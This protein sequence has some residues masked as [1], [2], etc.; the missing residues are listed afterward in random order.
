MKNGTGWFW[1]IA[2]LL[3]G[4]NESLAADSMAEWIKAFN[5]NYPVESAK[6]KKAVN[7]GDEVKEADFSNEFKELLYNLY[8]GYAS[9]ITDSKTVDASVTRNTPHFEFFKK[10]LGKLEYRE[11]EVDS[12]SDRIRTH[13]T[14]LEEKKYRFRWRFFVHY[15]SWQSQAAL[16]GPFETTSLLTTNLGF[17]P[18]IGTSLENRFW[19][20]S[21]DLSGLYGSGGVSAVQGLVEY[22]QSQVPA[23]GG[24]FA[25]GGGRIVSASGSEVGLRGSLLFVR[26]NLTKPSDSQYTVTQDKTLSY[27]ISV[28]SRWRF[29]KFY[30]ETD[31]G[32]T[33]ARPSTLWSIGL[34]SIF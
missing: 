5:K 10:A 9:K 23:L 17:C 13:L 18:G 29:N 34:G 28:F 30:L 16:V 12:T 33:I 25:I 4:A 26:Q 15:M 3:S 8:Q 20:L 24:R 14:H 11:D 21:L 32:R 2:M 1:A 31:F 6:I 19:S 22:Q 7:R 27:T